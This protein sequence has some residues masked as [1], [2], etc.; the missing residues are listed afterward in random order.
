MPI[1]AIKVY[2]ERLPTVN[3]EKKLLLVEPANSVYMDRGDKRRMIRA[4]QQTAFG[5]I[6]VKKVKK[7]DLPMI[8]LGSG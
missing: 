7:S 6:S 4:W 8:G 1:A 2:L 5:E 3:A